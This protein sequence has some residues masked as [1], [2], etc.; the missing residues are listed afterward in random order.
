MK[1]NSAVDSPGAA[2]SAFEGRDGYER[3]D[4][5]RRGTAALKAPDIKTGADK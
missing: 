1:S 2:M 4:A 3:S 5:K